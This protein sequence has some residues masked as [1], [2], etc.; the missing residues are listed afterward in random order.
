MFVF[1][2]GCS[3]LL[4]DLRLTQREC[5]NF[6]DQAT[7][8]FSHTVASA[9]SLPLPFVWLLPVIFA[10]IIDYGSLSLLVP[11]LSHISNGAFISLCIVIYA[12]QCRLLCTVRHSFFVP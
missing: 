6:V 7:R 12:S 3:S 9:G 10:D 11:L 4:I 8:D 2:D 1:L 5:V